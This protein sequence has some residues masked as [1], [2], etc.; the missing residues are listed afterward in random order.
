MPHDNPVPSLKRG[1][2]N[3]YRFITE[4]NVYW[5]GVG[6]ARQLIRELKI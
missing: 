3:D 1:R 5:Y 2:C 4:Y 6:S